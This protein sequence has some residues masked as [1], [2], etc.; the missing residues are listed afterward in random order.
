MLKLFFLVLFSSFMIL[1]CGSG[2]ESESTTPSKI[3]HLSI[4]KAPINSTPISI[5]QKVYLDFSANLNVSTVNDTTVYIKDANDVHIGLYIGIGNP[6]NRVVF[7]PYEYL[8]PASTYTIVVTTGV[9][10]IAG[11]S[12]SQDYTYS[13]TTLNEAINTDPLLVNGV[14]PN[15]NATDALVHTNISIEFNRNISLEPQ[16]TASGYVKVSDINTGIVVDGSVEVFNSVLKFI[17]S[18]PLQYD[19]NYSIELS[20]VISDLFANEYNTSN[21]NNWSFKTKAEVSSPIL[22]SG[23]AQMNTLETSKQSYHLCTIY[24]NTVASKI[25]VATDSGIDIYVVNYPI[26]NVYDLTK[27]ALEHLFSYTMGSQIKSM[28]SVNQNYLI[29]GT[30]DNGIYSFKV[31]T[32]TLAQV[33]HI[34]ATTP[35]YGLTAKVGNTGIIDKVYAVGPEFGLGILN[36]YELDGS[37]ELLTQTPA[38]GSI[39]L[40][41]LG[42]TVYDSNLQVEVPRIYAADYNGA[43]AIFDENGVKLGVTDINGSVKK[44]AYREDYNGLMGLYAITASGKVQGLGFD[45]SIFS[46]VYMELLNGISS[47]TSYVDSANILSQIYYSDSQKGVL[48]ANGGDYPSNIIQTNESIIAT[49]IVKGFTS[50]T[51]FLVLLSENGKL[52]IYNALADNNRPSIYTVPNH[53]GVINVSE[54][55]ISVEISDEYLDTSTITANSFILRDEN[56]SSVINMNLMNSKIGTY[57]FTAD[58]NFTVGHTYSLIIDGN[59]SDMIGNKINGGADHSIS[60]T[61]Q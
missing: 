57:Q 61:A 28:I 29:V 16:Y 31:E 8:E 17:P 3:S 35:I 53:T 11:N 33:S 46:N 60:F 13:F 15:D 39:Y 41:V 49:T 20:G 42:A 24:D 43:V 55:I 45:G 23:F 47:L 30:Q 56:T 59:I 52:S 27:P 12:L 10:D 14:K 22:N 6:D 7:T 54:G 25:A 1:G 2:S 4:S 9:E 48:I 18:A 38:N 40:D 51:P 44:L 50:S 5:M 21:G 34:Q 19:T 32:G 37:I 36:F 26:T 58:G